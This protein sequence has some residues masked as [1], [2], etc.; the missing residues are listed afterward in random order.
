MLVKFAVKAQGISHIEKNIPCQDTAAALLGLNNT[1][2]VAC[3]ADGHGGSKYF[4]S[5]RGSKIAVT[6]A[7]RSFLSFY[8]TIEREKTAFFYRK[9]GGDEGK[10]STILSSLKQLEGNI[11]YQW[12]NAVLDDLK[13]SPLTDTETEICKAHNIAFDDPSD[14][15]FL[16]GT[17]LLAGLISDSF[18]FTIQIG[19]GL[20][21]VIENE[22]KLTVPIQEDERNAFGRTTSLCGND[23]IEDFREAYGFSGIEGFTVATDGMADSFIPEKYLQFNK[24]LYEKFSLFPARAEID[25]QERLPELSEKGS[26]DDVSIAGIFRERNNNEEL[27]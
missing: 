9:T 25:L 17:T 26:R 14:L 16:Y 1:I 5:D 27:I 18:W 20:C 12:R 2:G 23:A 19:D 10:S 15:V 3:V 22:E 7:Q 4:R 6:I 11:I 24:E 13:E 21:V 8:G